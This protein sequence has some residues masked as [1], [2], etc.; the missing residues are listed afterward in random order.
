M[1]N[2]TSDT[3]FSE[4]NEQPAELSPA[5]ETSSQTLISYAQNSIMNPP[6]SEETSPMDISSRR[7]F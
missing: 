5:A 1:T 2:D 4:I 6:P 7:V 3:D